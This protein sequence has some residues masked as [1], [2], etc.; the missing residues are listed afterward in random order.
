M[1]RTT[2]SAFADRIAVPGGNNDISF[3]PSRIK[4][5]V[6]S[7]LTVALA[8]VPEAVAFAFVAGVHPLVGLY[9]A[10]IVG[11]I[12][13][14]FGGRPGMISGA[15]GALAVVMVALVAQHGGRKGAEA[16]AVFDLQVHHLLHLRTASIAEDT[17]PTKRAGAE[18]GRGLEPR[19]DLAISNSDSTVVDHPPIRVHRDDASAGQKRISPHFVI[20]NGGRRATSMVPSACISN[21][22]LSPAKPITRSGL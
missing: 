22:G 17:A 20:S 9:A 12:T 14:V 6:L 19:D 13:A 7:G 16:L 18:L 2:L 5:E 3:T 21:P 15:T 8:L 10:F 4:T 11:L 1:I